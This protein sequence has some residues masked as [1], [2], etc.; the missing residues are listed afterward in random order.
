MWRGHARP[1]RRQPSAKDPVTRQA[2]VPDALRAAQ[3]RRTAPQDWRPWTG[4][5]HGSSAQRVQGAIAQGGPAA[6][7]GLRVIG[8]DHGAVSLGEPANEC[9]HPH[10]GWVGEP[11]EGFVEQEQAR[12]GQHG[13]GKGEELLVSAGEGMGGLVEAGGEVGHGVETVDSGPVPGC[14][15]ALS[16]S[17][18]IGHGHGREQAAVLGEDGDA[19]PVALGCA[20]VVDR[21]PRRR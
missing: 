6:G 19:P 15:A 14:A 1:A 11:F 7:H 9:V 5:G 3:W 8:D 21:L 10:G 16:D 18:V 12:L 20:E 4:I 13:A 2:P 17:Q